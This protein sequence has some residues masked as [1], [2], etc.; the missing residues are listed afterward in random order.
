MGTNGIPDT[1][2]LRGRRSK[3]REAVQAPG[4]GRVTLGLA[5]PAAYHLCA[6]FS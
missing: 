3:V 1:N 5:V 2:P 6:M 4:L